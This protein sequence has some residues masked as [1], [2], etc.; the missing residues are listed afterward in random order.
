MQKLN[1]TVTAHDDGESV[2]LRIQDNGIGIDPKYQKEI[3]GKFKRLREMKGEQG[4]GLGLAI[5]TTVVADHGGY[6]R[7]KDNIP[8]GARFIVELPLVS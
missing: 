4:T 3:F 8:H 2:T 5:A 1:I 7:I 6:I